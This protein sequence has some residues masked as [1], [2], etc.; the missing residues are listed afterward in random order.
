M[1]QITVLKKW[2][3]HWGKGAGGEVGVR[4]IEPTKVSSWKQPTKVGPWKQSLRMSVRGNRTYEGQ[5]VETEPTTVSPWKQPTTVSPWKQSL[6]LSVHGNTAY[7]CQSVET[8]PT[9]V[10]PRLSSVLLAL[11]SQQHLAESWKPHTCSVM[12]TRNFSSSFFIPHARLFS[13]LTT[14]ASCAPPHTEHRFPAPSSK[15]CQ[16]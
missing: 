2:A 1:L 16:I 5:F 4:T 6:R 11:L 10:S 13:R 8:E 14:A 7:D 9:I 12:I 3:Q 15:L